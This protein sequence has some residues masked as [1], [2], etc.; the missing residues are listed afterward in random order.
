[1]A[2]A[3]RRVVEYLGLVDG[4]GYDGEATYTQPEPVRLPSDSESQRT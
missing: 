4:D 1:M 3:I 2:G